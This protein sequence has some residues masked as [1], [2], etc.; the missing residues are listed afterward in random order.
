MAQGVAQILLFP[1]SSV[2]WASASRPEMNGNYLLSR[3][4]LTFMLDFSIDKLLEPL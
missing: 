1:S 2:L 3:S 4:G